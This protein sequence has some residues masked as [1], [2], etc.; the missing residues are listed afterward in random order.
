M[1]LCL[2]LEFVFVTYL[3]ALILVKRS[4]R[5][6]KFKNQITIVTITYVCELIRVVLFISF[7]I[8]YYFVPSF[9]ANNI[10][11]FKLKLFYRTIILLCY[12]RHYIDLL[13]YLKQGC[14]I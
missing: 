3:V 8:C 11:C 5:G 1:I 9:D 10:L 13:F 2:K 7:S 6:N 4:K 14:S 12:Y